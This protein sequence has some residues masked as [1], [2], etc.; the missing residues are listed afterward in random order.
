MRT[1]SLVLKLLLFLYLGYLLFYLATGYE[2]ARRP[3]NPPFVIFV[4]DTIDL[5]IHEA[6]HFFMKPFGRFIEILGGSLVQC[7]I[8]LA[9][10]VV[11]WRQNIRTVPYGL[12]WLGANL[13]NV[14]VYIK[15]APYQ[16]LH[17]IASGLIHD[18]NWL[19]NG[20]PDVAEALGTGVQI[21]GI[22]ACFAAIGLGIWFAVK[23]YREDSVSAE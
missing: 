14:S 6:G 19:L 11:S 2:P 15:D 9:L 4:I 18:W 20:D 22:L 3:F 13:V 5:F 21:L 7:L 17:L 16:Q 8:P 23:T 10:V 12:F 1:A